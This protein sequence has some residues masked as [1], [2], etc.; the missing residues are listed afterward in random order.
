MV[1][2]R[3]VVREDVDYA[4]EAIRRAFGSQAAPALRAAG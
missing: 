1:T 4:V 2:H 3:G